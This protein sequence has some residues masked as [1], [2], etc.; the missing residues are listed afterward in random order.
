MEE[1]KAF[2]ELLTTD[3]ENA[4]WAPVAEL[5]PEVDPDEFVFSSSFL[6]SIVLTFFSAMRYSTSPT[7]LEETTPFLSRPY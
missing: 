7:Y 2:V 6:S 1:V 4:F 3:G 5:V